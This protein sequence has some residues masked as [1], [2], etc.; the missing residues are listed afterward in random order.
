M[1]FLFA[2]IT[3]IFI[4]GYPIFTHYFMKYK[5]KTNIN[6]SDFV[7]RYSSLFFT[8]KLDANY[9]LYQTSM[10]LIRRLFIVSSVYFFKESP[11]L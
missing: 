1:N 2:V 9:A 11:Y 10:F 5:V 4:L 7:A 3:S 8:L 6:N